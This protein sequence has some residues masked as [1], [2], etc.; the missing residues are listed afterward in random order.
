MTGAPERGVKR[1]SN[2]GALPLKPWPETM[3]AS[4]RPSWIVQLPPSRP[5]L[6][7][8]VQPS[9]SSNAGS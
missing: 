2:S 4:T 7:C 3:Y 8:T 9:G 1:T 5:A 6:L